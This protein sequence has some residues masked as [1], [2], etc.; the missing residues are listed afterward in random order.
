MYKENHMNTRTLSGLVMHEKYYYLGAFICT[1]LNIFIGFVTPALLAELMDHYLGNQASRFPVLINQWVAL[2]GG[3]DY[4]LKNLWLFGAGL[5]VLNVFK[6][7]FDYF[8]WRWCAFASERVSKKMRDRLYCHIQSLP[9]EY[10]VKVEAGDLI[11]RCTS[12]VETIRRFLNVQLITVFNSIL[13]IVIAL[14]LMLPISRKITLLSMLPLPLMILFSWKFFGVVIK[15]YRETEDAEGRMSTVLQENLSGVRVVR[16]FGQQQNETERFEEANRNHHT[17][18]A[19]MAKLDA[20]FWTSSDLFGAA[21]MLI[22]SIVCILE[23][24][25]GHISLGDTIVLTAYAGMLIGPTRQMG[26][27]LSDSGK[28]MVALERIR[29][30]LNEKPEPAESE[31]VKPSL[32]GDIVFDDVCFSYNGQ[33]NVLN[34]ISMTIKE[35]QTIAILGATGSG[36]STLVHLLQRLYEPCSGEIRIG[37]TPL[38]RIDR[39]HLRSRVGLVLQ[40]PFLYS[41]TIRDN[42][43]IAQRDPDQQS[44]E[45]AAESAAALDFINQSEN[46][47]NTVVGEKGVTLSGGQKQRIAIARTL[48]KESD[49]LIF[50]DSLSAVDNHT[51]ALIRE[52]LIQHGKSIT[53]LIISHRMTTLSKADCIFVLENG[54]ISQQGTHEELLNMPGLYRNIYQIQS[55]DAWQ[56]QP[57]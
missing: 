9:F 2:L 20:S 28:T 8:K 1:A 55:G 40:E 5:I 57:N 14:A 21:Q 52:S 19:R 41:K 44:I 32:R 38:S 39:T 36:K 10:H 43:G 26:R 11:Q 4:M 56:N 27:I 22:V 51:D 6:G 3:R 45:Q 17:A 49:I 37:G 35:G 53:T 25:S 30:I 12:D 7:T 18:G 54:Q 23:A 15:A 50:D 34:H 24:V 47:F 13:M 31:A 48:M 29:H 42:I 33:N 46:G 16:A